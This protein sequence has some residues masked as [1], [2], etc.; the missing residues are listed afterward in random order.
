MYEHFC[1]PALQFFWSATNVFCFY[2]RF[3]MFHPLINHKTFTGQVS[4]ALCKLISEIRSTS[5]LQ[6]RPPSPPK[7]KEK[8]G[9]FR[10]KTHY[11][12]IAVDVDVAD[13]LFAIRSESKRLGE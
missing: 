5:K 10:R 2:Q 13:L 3:S 7:K 11:P 6:L 9:S 1:V 4:L 8:V 12:T